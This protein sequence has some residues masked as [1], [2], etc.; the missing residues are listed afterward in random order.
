MNKDQKLL[1]EAYTNVYENL[2][3]RPEAKFIDME[4]GRQME[5]LE[6]LDK[7]ALFMYVMRKPELKK[8]LNYLIGTG[9]MHEVSRF[10]NNLEKS[11]NVISNGFQK[12]YLFDVAQ[13]EHFA[14]NPK[15]KE[16]HE[17]LKKKL[18]GPL[19]GHPSANNKPSISRLAQQDPREAPY[20]QTYGEA[21]NI[22][23]MKFTGT[24]WHGLGGKDPAP[25][26]TFDPKFKGSK[27][28][29]KKMQDVNLGGGMTKSMPEYSL[30]NSIIDALEEHGDVS[31]KELAKAVA[32]VFNN[33][34]S[35]KF[36]RESFIELLKELIILK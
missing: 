8:E 6:E 19:S 2:Y 21:H 32:E 33:E 15:A 23:P 4:D 28:F 25:K 14:K 7:Q 12:S 24:E 34:Y 9:A 26:I 16:E 29:Q 35:N 31:Y 13:E 5:D 20:T 17:A 1:A 30:S 3:G 22:N 36:T 18:D 11:Q 27:G 10:I